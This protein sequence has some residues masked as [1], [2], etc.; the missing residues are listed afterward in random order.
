LVLKPV[1]RTVF[2]SD[3]STVDVLLVDLSLS[4]TVWLLSHF[5]LELIHVGIE[6]FSLLLPQLSLLEQSTYLVNKRKRI[7][8][9]RGKGRVP[10]VV[11]DE[12]G[13]P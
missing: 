3:E 7:L 1:G 4:L 11:V 10:E 9:L 12:P 13:F 2:F 6:E 5:L 8:V